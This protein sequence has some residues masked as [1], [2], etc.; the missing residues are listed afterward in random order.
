[1]PRGECGGPKTTGGKARSARRG[2]SCSCEIHP[3]D[4]RPTA[5]PAAVRHVA[6]GFIPQIATLA[7][8]GRKR[9]NECPKSTRFYQTNSKWNLTR[10]KMTQ[11]ARTVCTK[12]CPKLPIR[13]T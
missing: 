8:G 1:M 4:R 5:R 2:E 11:K 12:T 7:P 10:P 13:A 6:A 3:A 9:H